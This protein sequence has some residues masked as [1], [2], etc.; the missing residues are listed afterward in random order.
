MAESRLYQIYQCPK[1]GT[2]RRRVHTP[3]PPP[4]CQACDLPMRWRRTATMVDPPAPRFGQAPG[5]D[6]RHT[7]PIEV[8]I[9]G[10]MRFE[11]L[12]ELRKFERESELLASEG[13][14]QPY[15]V[16]G[17]SQDRSNQ[18]VNTL[19]EPVWETPNLLDAKGRPRIKITS[20]EAP[21]DEGD[22]E[23]GPGAV[24]DLASA[25]PMDPV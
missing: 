23:M 10:G 21:Q 5:I 25:L 17:Y 12:A 8:P 1:C 19:G 3:D 20:H 13:I 18:H 4:T 11:S 15:V 9:G 6:F 16:R 7:S 24:G 2:A 14:G 22:V